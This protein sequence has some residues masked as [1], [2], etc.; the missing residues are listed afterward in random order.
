[1][2][3]T[4]PATTQIQSSSPVQQE[5]LD[6]GLLTSGFNCILQMPTGSGKTWLAEQAIATVLALGHRAIYLTPL[7]ALADELVTR[8]QKRFSP[9]PVGVF[10]GD[11]T[12]RSYPVPYQDAQLL[13]MTPE[14]LDACT[15]RWRSHWSWMPE[16]D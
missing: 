6:R 11:Y 5:I 12:H 4:L 15:R 8:W 10:T 3:D 9:M 14:R 1:M 13:V 2:F 7:R 16:V